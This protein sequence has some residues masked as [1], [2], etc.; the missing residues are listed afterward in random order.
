MILC[1]NP[2]K[3]YL[4]R[5]EKIDAAIRRVLD[6]GWYVLGEE[7]RQFE[8]EFANFA[9]CRHGIGVG[10][11]TDAIHLA[12]RCLDVGSGD[13]VITVAHTA[14]ATV[15][16]IEL[17]GAKTVFAD[18]C[19]DTFTI[20]PDAVKRLLTPRTKAII[21]VHLYGQAVNL[22]PILEMARQHGIKVIE[23]CAQ[24]HGAMYKGRIV[25]SLG[26]LACFSFYPTK[27]LG[28]IGDGGMVT[29]RSDELA[30]KARLLREYGWQERYISLVSGWNTRLDELQAA[31]LRV[32]LEHLNGDNEKRRAIA[33]AYAEGLGDLGLTLPCEME[34]NK[35]VFHLYVIRTAQRD[36]LLAHLKKQEIQAAVHYP[37]PIHKQ[38]AYKDSY[39]SISLPITELVAQD[40]LSLPMYPELEDKEVLQVI[41][42]VR[43]FFKS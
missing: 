9:G 30:A 21:A 39:A 3:Q 38:P 19:P 11:G 22:D 7:V 37:L 14:V 13:E 34:N 42:G 8:K 28:A 31:I 4:A 35:H 26:D 15:A 32:K 36:G 16:A 6:G 33:K 2:K 10:N 12:L 18:I 29:T 23:D 20:D 25:G 43:S 27:N 41:Q 5:K 1:A 17:T 24:A 40:V